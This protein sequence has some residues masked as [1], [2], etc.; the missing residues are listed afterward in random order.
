MHTILRAKKQAPAPPPPAPARRDKHS[1]AR[2]FRLLR[3]ARPSRFPV[4]AAAMGA[5]AAQMAAT[6]SVGGA[7]RN[8]TTYRRCLARQLAV[9]APLMVALETVVMADRRALVAIRLTNRLG[10]AIR[11]AQ[12]ALDA[13]AAVPGNGGASGAGGATGQRPSTVVGLAT[14]PAVRVALSRPQPTASSAS[15]GSAAGGGSLRVPPV[16][17]RTSTDVSTSGT[18]SHWLAAPSPAASSG[19]ALTSPT[20]ADKT[21][22]AATL[23]QR[24][25]NLMNQAL[26]SQRRGAG[27]SLAASAASTPAPTP[28]SST[29]GKGVAG[30]PGSS[31]SAGTAAVSGRPMPRLDTSGSG[32]SGRPPVPSFLG[33]VDWLRQG[34]ASATTQPWELDAS[35]RAATVPE[36]KRPDLPGPTGTCAHTA[37]EVARTGIK[38]DMSWMSAAV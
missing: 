25:S 3:R 36:G 32:S 15:A 10:E 21:S 34:A 14:P 12:L 20:T 30:A 37:G 11:D 18:S 28:L 5:S 6:R 31:G 1:R 29:T 23:R 22:V 26:M 16:L 13:S 17:T 8:V 2:R 19:G 27:N 38:P 7:G 35:L 4:A 9:V 24:A 33:D